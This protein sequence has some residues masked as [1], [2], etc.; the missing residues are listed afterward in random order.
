MVQF[1]EKPGKVN[2][3]APTRENIISGEYPYR[4]PLYL[5]INRQARPETR[6]F[7][8]FVLGKPGQALISSYGMP[9]LSDVK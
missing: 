3:I 2:G 1:K 6:N 7:V 9:T 4:R 5:V 8:D